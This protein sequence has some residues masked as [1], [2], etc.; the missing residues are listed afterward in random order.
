[1]D[2]LPFIAFT[3][4]FNLHDLYDMEMEDIEYWFKQAEIYVKA[5]YR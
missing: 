5:I 4:H 2:V 1:M 3:F